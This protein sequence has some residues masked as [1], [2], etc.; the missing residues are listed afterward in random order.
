MIPPTFCFKVTKFKLLPLNPTSPDFREFF[1]GELRRSPQITSECK[2]PLDREEFEKSLKTH[3]DRRLLWTLGQKTVWV[4]QIFVL[5]FVVIS[6]LYGS[7]AYNLVN[8]EID[9]KA[10]EEEEMK[11]NWIIQVG[12]YINKISF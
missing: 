11:N 3:R 5:Q 9:L 2:N 10:R 4:T 12:D 1:K 8:N 6:A 7:A